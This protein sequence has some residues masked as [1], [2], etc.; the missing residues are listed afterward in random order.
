[1]INKQ[2]IALP[3][4]CTH[5]ELEMT[6]FDDLQDY[7]LIEI[8]SIEK[9][10]CIH[11][12]HISNLERIIRLNQELNLNFEGID[13]VINLLNKIDALQEELNNTRNRLRRFE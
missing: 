1:M 8:V 2:Y 5:Y 10:N 11:Y 4:L 13:T 6:F 3:D 9:T 7:G 12:D